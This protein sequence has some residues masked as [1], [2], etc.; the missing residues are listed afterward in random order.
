ML[1]GAALPTVTTDSDVAGVGS[2]Q[3]VLPHKRVLSHVVTGPEVLVR[4]EV[5]VKGE[6]EVA[7]RATPSAATTASKMN[8]RIAL[9]PPDVDGSCRR[10]AT[11]RYATGSAATAPLLL[12]RESESWSW[13]S[14]IPRGLAYRRR[15]IAEIN[16]GVTR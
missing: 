11:E 10:L 7:S 12:S 3:R 15:A 2:L 8:L 1:L 14:R 5:M 4:V 16:C 13:L 6:A 9:L